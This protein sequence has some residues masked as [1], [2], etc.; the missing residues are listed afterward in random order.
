M[1][2]E[3]ARARPTTASALNSRIHTTAPVLPLVRNSQ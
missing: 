2:A 3:N 1:G